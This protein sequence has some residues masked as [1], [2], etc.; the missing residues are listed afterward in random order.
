MIKNKDILDKKL[1]NDTKE[2][3]RHLNES[4]DQ[5]NDESKT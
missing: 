3:S 1:S 4:D 5:N 2:L